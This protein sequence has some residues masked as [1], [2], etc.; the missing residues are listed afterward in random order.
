MPLGKLLGSGK[1]MSSQTGDSIHASGTRLL[2]DS[3]GRSTVPE[4]GAENDHGELMPVFDS[5][6]GIYHHGDCLLWRFTEV[7]SLSSNTQSS[8]P[9]PG[10]A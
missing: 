7:D 5:F 10:I 3:S 4:G 8:Y 6:D 9:G 2:G 1:I